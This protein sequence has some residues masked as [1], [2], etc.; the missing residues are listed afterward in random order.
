MYVICVIDEMYWTHLYQPQRHW[1]TQI[2]KNVL[3]KNAKSSLVS[4]FI[5]SEIGSID[6]TEIRQGS[7]KVFWIAVS[8]RRQF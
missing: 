6:L 4:T 2:L 8:Y 3:L 5:T 7:I 1:N